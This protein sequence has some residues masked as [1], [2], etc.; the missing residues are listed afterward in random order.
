MGTDP[1]AREMGAGAPKGTE[2]SAEEPK[3]ELDGGAKPS[4]L[5]SPHNHSELDAYQRMPPAELE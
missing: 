1:N 2:M 3:K 4:E 5:D